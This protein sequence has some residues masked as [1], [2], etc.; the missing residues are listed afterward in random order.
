[1]QLLIYIMHEE[2]LCFPLL[3]QMSQKG[4]KQLSQSPSGHLA[5]EVDPAASEH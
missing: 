1:M 4:L 3:D 2:N 5:I